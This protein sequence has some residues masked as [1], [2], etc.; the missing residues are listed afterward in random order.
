MGVGKCGCGCR[1][2]DERKSRMLIKCFNFGAFKMWHFIQMKFGPNPSLCIHSAVRD[3]FSWYTFATRMAKIYALATLFIYSV[4]SRF[5]ISK[6]VSWLKALPNGIINM[7]ESVH[8][9]C[10]YRSETSK[11]RVVWEHRK[12]AFDSNQVNM[13]RQYVMFQRMVDLRRF[14]VHIVLMKSLYLLRL[15]KQNFARP[16]P[17]A[18]E[19]NF[20]GH[21]MAWHKWCTQYFSHAKRFYS[22]YCF[23]YI[24]FGTINVF[25]KRKLVNNVRPLK[26]DFSS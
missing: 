16:K 23:F 24:S 22:H 11:R 5:F 6:A 9:F 8:I 25:R 10:E 21:S 17:F 20:D 14:L 3:D 18:K 26:C 15:I 7:C 13:W 4:R 2:V 1:K 12:S 19:F